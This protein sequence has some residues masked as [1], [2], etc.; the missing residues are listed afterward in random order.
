MNNKEILLFV[1][2]MARD[3]PLN[4]PLDSDIIFAVEDF[5][6][7]EITDGIFSRCIL[8][9]YEGIELGTTET[10]EQVVNRVMADWGLT[11]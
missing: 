3:H 8:S 4:D 1:A 10:N 5:T 7:R 2:E 11:S 6:E 9:V